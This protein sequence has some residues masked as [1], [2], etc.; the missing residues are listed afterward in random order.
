MNYYGFIPMSENFPKIYPRMACGQLC[1]DDIYS[2]NLFF[3][4]T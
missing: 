4:T 2:E 1:M 3:F